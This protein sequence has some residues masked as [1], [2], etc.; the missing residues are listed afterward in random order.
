MAVARA[1]IFLQQIPLELTKDERLLAFIPIND[2][3]RQEIVDRLGRRNAWS[4]ATGTS[5]AWVV[6]AFVFTLIDSFVS[7]NESSSGI[8]EGLAI[9]TIWLWL[10]CL[11]IGWLWVPT[12]TCSE[13]KSAIG[14]AN[15][16][17]SRL[18]E[19]IP[20][21]NGSK[22]P[23]AN[24]APGEEESI[25]EDTPFQLSPEGQQGHDHSSISTIPT[26]NQSAVTLTL[27]AEGLSITQNP[28]HPETDR[29]LI[30]EDKFNSLN[31]DERRL[32]ATFNYSRIMRYL[33][34]VDD[35]LR[36]LDELTREKDEVGLSR[37]RLMLEVVSLI[38]TEAK[39]DLWSHCHSVHKGRC[40]PSGSPHLDVQGV[41]F[42]PHSPVRNNR[43]GR[44]RRNL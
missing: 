12:F 29:L 2:Q 20:I 27:S 37:N 33:A 25:Q 31:R 21:P 26:A 6:I 23:V 19:Q 41:Y 4:I 44:D 3:W 34:L 35:V 1:L 30:P 28:I 36:A 40:V 14:H 16:I 24:P 5:I 17:T 18:P 8:F 39:V 15:R 42:C 43:R 10:L 38:P 7:L 13:L 9:G 11:V 32:A 22:K